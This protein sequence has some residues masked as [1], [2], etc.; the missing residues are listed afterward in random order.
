[1]TTKAVRKLAEERRISTDQ[2]EMLR[3]MRGLTNEGIVKL[4]EKSLRS[5]LRRVDFPDMPRQRQAFRIMQAGLYTEEERS[6]A[7]ER[8]LRQL[9]SLRL[10]TFTAERAGLRTGGAVA[11]A[12][13]GI[14]PPPPAAGLAPR[15]WQSIGPSNIGGRTRS[16]VVHPTDPDTIWVGQRRRRRLAKQRRR[17]ELGAGR[18]FHGQPRGHHHGHG[19]G[20][21][22]TAST[23]APA[24]GLATSTRCAAPA[25]SLRPTAPLGASSPRPRPL[26]SIRVNRL[27]ISA[28]R[29]S[30]SPP[31]Q[32]AS[33]AAPTPARLVWTRVLDAASPTSSSTRPIDSMRSPAASIPAKPMARTD[34]GLSWQSATHSGRWDGRVELCYAAADPNRVYASIDV[35]RGE[36]WRSTERREDVRAAQDPAMP[37]E[38]RPLPGRPGM[39]RQRH[40]GGRPD[41]RQPGHR[42]RHRPLAQHRRRRHAEGH[43]HMVGQRSAHADHHC[44]V[45]APRLQRHDQQDVFFGNDGGVYRAD[46][47]HRRS[48]TSHAAA[49]KGWVELNTLRRHPVLRRG[50][51]RRTPA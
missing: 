37:T 31:R 50:G 18:R 28:D 4:P 51:Q 7:L 34:G 40:L 41:Q 36:I 16:I 2:V 14:A 29:P 42:R 3:E 9:D 39:V 6:H 25:S 24:R 30:C 46:R 43:Q 15:Q 23:P 32:R 8:A 1:M 11:A 38:R 12:R 13:I 22:R 27:A 47:R 21:R 20:R 33:S 17:Q 19:P 26:T 44:I 49:V 45:A 5:S 35:D 48:A 10:R